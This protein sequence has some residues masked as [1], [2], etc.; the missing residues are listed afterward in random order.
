MPQ[1]LDHLT[2]YVLRAVLVPVPGRVIVVTGVTNETH[3]LAYERC[4]PSGPTGNGRQP[5]GPDQ[6]FTGGLDGT[7]DVGT[8][9]EF[10]YYLDTHSFYQSNGERGSL[11][12]PR[13]REV[14][15]WGFRTA[16]RIGRAFS[17]RSDR[18]FTSAPERAP[19]LE[20]GAL[21]A[22]VEVGFPVIRQGG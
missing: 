9:G 17:G 15:G 8:D 2:D 14:G 12:P 20:A 13:R 4:V 1:F 22:V 21:E 5:R 7:R 10:L 11:R 18:G 16:C 6:I 3:F 19:A